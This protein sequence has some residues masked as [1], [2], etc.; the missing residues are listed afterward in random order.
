MDERF[1]ER[2]WNV[3]KE[4]RV[5]LEQLAPELPPPVDTCEMIVPADDL[6]MIYRKKIKEWEARGWRMDLKKLYETRTRMAYAIPSPSRQG[7]KNW[8]VPAVPLI[9]PGQKIEAA[10]E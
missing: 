3:A 1:H 8:P 2:L 4:D 6:L 9:P 7:M 10:A 5:V